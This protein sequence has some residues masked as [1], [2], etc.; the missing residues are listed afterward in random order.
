MDENQ[1]ES[2]LPV[3]E[4]AAIDETPE[5]EPV[6]DVAEETSSTPVS[7][8]IVEELS[9]AVDT[10]RAELL[11]S[12]EELAARQALLEASQ[13]Q[14][15]KLEYLTT[16]LFDVNERVSELSKVV[17][18]LSLELHKISDETEQTVTM[19][20]KA[21]V[22]SALSRWFLVIAIV[23]LLALLAGLSYLAVNQL[24]LQQRQ[25]KLS[26][27]ATSAVESQEKQLT[28]FEKH[29]ADMIGSGIKSELEAHNKETGMGKLN[30][31]RNGA[32][33]QRLLRKSNGDW[34]LPSAKHEELITDPDTIE[35]LNQGFEK[36]GR[37]LLTPVNTP[38][39]KVVTLLKP[40]GKGGTAVVVTRETVP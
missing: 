5:L 21:K 27:V 26:L 6:P 37:S 29:F 38:P 2:P 9:A 30:H 1:T 34:L 23:L 14:L 13:E 24:Q 32:A 19:F 4:D 39:H 40:D 8:T 31:L 16:T 33:E 7:D 18:A 36:S 20:G 22:N 25:D 12:V 17:A 11:P 35:A 3:A 15:T 10:A 28:A